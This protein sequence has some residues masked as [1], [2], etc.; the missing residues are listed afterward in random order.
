MKIFLFVLLVVS[1]NI[2]SS[3]KAEKNKS[4]LNKKDLLI[5]TITVINPV[6][7]VGAIFSNAN[8]I[9]KILSMGNLA[10]STVKR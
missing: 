5:T 4:L 10:Y 1:F 8:T 3:S 6:I 9:S 7:S 2:A